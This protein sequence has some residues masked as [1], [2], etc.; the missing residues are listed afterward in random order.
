MKEIVRFAMQGVVYD[1]YRVEGATSSELH[2]HRH[3]L[4]TLITRGAGVQCL[5]GREIPF[6]AGDVFLLSPTDFHKNILPPGESYDYFG[7]KFN[8]DTLDPRLYAVLGADSFP[9][10]LSLAG[11]TYAAV[12]AA[13]THLVSG[14]PPAVNTAVADVYRK[15]L[16]EQ[17]II[18]VMPYIKR[19]GDGVQSP[20]AVCVLGYLYAHLAERIGVSD[21]AAYV[22]YTPNYFNTR[23]RETF[24]MPF[25]AYLRAVRLEYAKNLV[26]SGDLPLTEVAF[27]AGFFSLACFSR[28]FKE[29][30]GASPQQ[31]RNRMREGAK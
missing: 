16:L 20:F 5:N 7:V 4:L 31:Y 13:F 21:A 8:F 15:A 25:G 24:G 6:A 29:K 10:H 22:G 12:H 11:E 17:I 26:L 23:F 14:A 2:G 9:I 18:T 19:E 1:A 30:Y 27:E 28:C 3:F